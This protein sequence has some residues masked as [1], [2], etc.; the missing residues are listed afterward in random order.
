[1]DLVRSISGVRGIVGTSLTPAVVSNYV[2]AF[3]DILP[4]GDII[5]GR[6]GRKS[7]FWIEKMITGVLLSM[8][9]NVVLVGIAPTPTIQVLVKNL[10]ASGGISI[11]ASHN[12]QEWNGLKFLGEEGICLNKYQNR[13]LFEIVDSCVF[14]CSKDSSSTVQILHNPLEE[15]INKVLG[16]PIFKDTTILDEIRARNFKVVVDAIN[17]SGSTIIP[18]LLRE[19]NCDVVELNCNGN[20]EFVHNPE[21]IPENLEGLSKVVKEQRADIGFAVDPDA[22][23]LVLIDENGTPVWEE[24]TIVLAVLFVSQ[25]LEYFYPQSNCV[26][27]NFSTTSLVDFVARKYGLE[28]VRSPVG[29]VNVVEKM[30]ECRAVVGGEGSGGVILPACHYGRDSL[31]GIVLML[32]LL[33]KQKKPLSHILDEFPKTFMK[34]LKIQTSENLDEAVEQ[35]ISS[36]KVSMLDVNTEDGFRINFDG[37]F[38]HIRKSNTE[39][40]V[41]IAF[42]TNTENEFSSLYRLVSKT[43]GL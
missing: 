32:S 33:T 30:R 17:S 25:F 42:E 13:K 43:F 18:K 21:P 23:R 16:L 41:R 11:T 38:L 6:D 15:H 8:N 35:I 22:D 19:L 31:V 20:G 2:T 26:V 29:E 39:P 14:K 40:L 24:M 5:V 34:K 28:V 1:M 3:T 12:T 37:G 4:E 10:K 36:L 27:V 7:G 9:R